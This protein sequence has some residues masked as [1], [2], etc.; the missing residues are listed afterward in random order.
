MRKVLASVVGSVLLSAAPSFGD[1][2]VVPDRVVQLDFVEQ[3]GTLG[4]GREFRVSARTRAF[5]GSTDPLAGEVF[6]GGDG[7]PPEFVLE[8]FEI[9]IEGAPVALPREAWADLSDPDLPGGIRVNQ[10][11]GALVVHVIGGDGAGSYRVSLLIRDGRLV[12]Q[13]IDQHGRPPRVERF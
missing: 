12:A 13:R 8:R 4:D 9:A 10:G 6:L 7:D 3:G 2:L 1:D 5:G 11:D